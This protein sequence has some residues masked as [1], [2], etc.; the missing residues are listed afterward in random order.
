MKVKQESSMFYVAVYI[1]LSKEDGDKE[2]SDSVG[3]QRKIITEY[4]EKNPECIIQEM[5]IDDGY[6]GINF[7]RPAFQRMI[8]DIEA[9]IINCVIVKD[10]SR[11]GRDYIETGR[12]LERYFPELKVRFISLTDGIDSR[13]KEY[14][15]L[16]PIKNIFNEQYARDISKKVQTTIVAKQ[17]AGEFIGSFA[18]YGYKKS[19]LNKN[20][21]VVDTYAAEVVRT[22]YSFYIKGYTKQQIAKMLD[23][24]GILC[25]TEY[26]KVSGLNYRNN[27]CTRSMSYWSYSTINSILHHEIYIGN[28][29]QGTKHQRMRSK[30]YN[31]ERENW[32]IVA[33]T[34]EAI[35]D[36]ETWEK[37][38]ILLKKGTRGQ[39][40][41]LNSNIFAGFVT[42]GTCGRAMVA[43]TW[44]RADGS[45]GCT[46]Y[47][48]TYK[49]SGT[50]FCT[51]HKISIKII[52]DIV[53][54]DMK[55]I[56]KKI[57]NLNEL[58]KNED[59]TISRGRKITEKKEKKELE[60]VK[61]LKQAIY[62]DYK[63]GIINK[64]EFD[65]YYESYQRKETLY[66]KQIQ[67][68]DKI[69]KES[70]EKDVFKSTWVKRLL[71]NKDIEKL[72]RECVIEMIDQIVIYEHHQIKIRY[73]FSNEME[74]LFPK[75]YRLNTEL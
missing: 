7:K 60:R 37:V 47:C 19:E 45:R 49:R 18:S 73:K 61:R 24:D 29:V 53:I 51:A 44:K 36:K 4:L 33:D 23:E 59:K 25:P 68:L 32:K 64:Q 9:G 65:T 16:L 6:T 66:T 10:L 62:E 71:E 17:K 70:M 35:I 69:K 57:D 31:V 56:I 39:N 63:E 34:H 42:C 21:L 28:M 30:Q 50:E 75:Q 13:K 22:I 58:I 72:D 74:V 15:M 48:G 26:K 41:E 11:F 55:M 54:N 46:F 14:D 38:Q 3:N 2:E 20:K 40:V 1:R 52:E 8:A 43:T 27:R 12:Y 67:V 5:Y